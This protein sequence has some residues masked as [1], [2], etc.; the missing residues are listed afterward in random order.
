[1]LTAV[2]REAEC[3]GCSRCIPACPVDAIIGT[4]KF[5]HT[6]LLDECIGCGLCVD[7]CPVDCIEMVTLESMVPPGT[8]INKQ[9]RADKAKQRHRARQTRLAQEEQRVL[10]VYASAEERQTK[11]KQEIK[12]ALSR[13]QNKKI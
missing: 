10:P 7:P 11:I 13:V 3:I 12:E 8:E 6:V 4:N 9:Q 1:M 5:L 2:I